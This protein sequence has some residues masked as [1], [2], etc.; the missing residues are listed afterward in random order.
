MTPQS[1]AWRE[2]SASG[3]LA[4]FLLV[5]LGAYLHAAD[6]LV[7]AT[8]VPATTPGGRPQPKPGSFHILVLAPR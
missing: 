8:L 6:T 3:G 4:R 7:T 5:C 2:L 1:G